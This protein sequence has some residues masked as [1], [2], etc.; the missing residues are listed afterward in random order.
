MLESGKGRQQ[1]VSHS[2]FDQG[3]RAL[4]AVAEIPLAKG[5]FL[6]DLVLDIHNKRGRFL[7]GTKDQVPAQ[8]LSAEGLAVCQR[9]VRGTD[10][11]DR[12]GKQL[13]EAEQGF[14]GFPEAEG[15]LKLG[16]L[17]HSQDRVKGDGMDGRVNGRKFFHQS[18]ENRRKKIQLKLA[19]AADVKKLNIFVPAKAFLG[20]K[21]GFQD[22]VRVREKQDPFCGQ[23]DTLAGP[24]EKLDI[25]LFFQG[26]DLMADCGLG[27]LQLFGSFGKVQMLGY[28]DKTF[29]LYGIHK[30]LLYK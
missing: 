7:G 19:P 27:D 9:E 8:E 22:V 1:G 10:T 24:G 29:Q 11:A 4:D 28:S 13:P 2:G 25:E 6:S 17:H 5:K 26:T 23:R 14:L 15:G 3:E 21:S 12:T 30:S 18:P 16:F 20:G